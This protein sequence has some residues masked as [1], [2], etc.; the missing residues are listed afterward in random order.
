MPVTVDD[1]AELLNQGP[2]RSVPRGLRHRKLQLGI[3]I[4]GVFF[5]VFSIPFMIL[6]FPWRVANTLRLKAGPTERATGTVESAGRTNMSVNDRPVY[7]A[8]FRFMPADG[9]GVRRGTCYTTG[10]HYS[11]GDRVAV[12]YVASRPDICCIEGARLDMAG[13]AAGFVAIFPLVGAGMLAGRGLSRRRYLGL[14]KH[15]TFARGRIE[16]VR[17]TNI[18]VNNQQRYKV[19]VSYESNGEERTVSYN[20]YGHEVE[21]ARRKLQS[22]DQVGVLYDVNRPKRVVVLDTLLE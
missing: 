1:I 6:F 22:A 20:A 10:E 17:S 11:E 21:L 5:L 19:T 12:R 15:G 2:P 13:L 16:S 3:L 9:S 14:L 8:R 4:F 18:T 7:E